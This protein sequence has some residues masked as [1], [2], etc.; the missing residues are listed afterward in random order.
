MKHLPLKTVML[1][2]NIIRRDDGYELSNPAGTAWY[3]SHGV[4]GKVE[5]IPEYFP[6]Q[7]NFA[8]ELISSGSE[9]IKVTDA[10]GGIRVVMKALKECQEKNKPEISTLKLKVELDTSEVHKAL[11]DIDKRIRDSDFKTMVS[12]SFGASES[13]M[14]GDY[15]P[16]SLLPAKK[17]DGLVSDSCSMR[18]NKDEDGKQYAAGMSVGVGGAT[19]KTRLSDDM[20]DAVIDAVRESGL[21]A[22]LIPQKEVVFQ[23]EHFTVSSGEVKLAGAVIS[24]ALASANALKQ[25]QNGNVITVNINAQ[26]NDEELSAVIAKAI[27]ASLRPGG[28]IHNSIQK[29]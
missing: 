7:I 19:T 2:L 29:R 12:F 6:R 16:E 15:A 1:G 4:R 17:A 28:L 21:F 22:E 20:R 5:G 10:D 18:V 3:D 11:D 27:Q 13:V 23:A 24:N 14:G 26:H 25:P 8:D 9:V